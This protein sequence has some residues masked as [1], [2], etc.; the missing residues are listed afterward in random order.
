MVVS[1][2]KDMAR[3]ES[4]NS[5]TPDVGDPDGTGVALVQQERGAESCAADPAI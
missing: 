3:I 4:V 1:L 2:G 5:S